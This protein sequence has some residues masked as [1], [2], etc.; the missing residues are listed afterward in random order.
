MTYWL[1]APGENAED[2]Y[3]S[4]STNKM[5]IG[6]DGAGIKNLNNYKS[7]ESIEKDINKGFSF[8]EYLTHPF[9]V[10]CCWQFANEINIGDIIFARGGVKKIIGYGIV[11]SNYQYDANGKE[12]FKHNRDVEWHPLEYEIN[13]SFGLPR[14]TLTLIKDNYKINELCKICNIAE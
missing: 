2:W 7:R 11:K 14:K 1:F 6:Y 9:H 5:Y 13:T 12:G 3:F 4:L 8:D 10:L